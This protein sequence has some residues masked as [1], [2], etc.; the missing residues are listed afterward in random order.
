MGSEA[1]AESRRLAD[2]EHALAA[3]R[4][5][6]MEM[7]EREAADDAARKFKSWKPQ[8]EMD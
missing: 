2:E 3:R 5:L 4:R 8:A 6:E 1:E 7:A